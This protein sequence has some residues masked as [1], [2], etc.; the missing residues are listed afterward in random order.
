MPWVFRT[1]AYTSHGPQPGLC[2][3][4]ASLPQTAAPLLPYEHSPPPIDQCE[5]SRSQHHAC[6][7][8]ASQQGRAPRHYLLPECR[9]PCVRSSP[10]PFVQRRRWLG[11]R[12][13]GN[14]QGAQ[15]GSQRPDRRHRERVGQP[16]CCRCSCNVGPESHSGQHGGRHLKRDREDTDADTQGHTQGNATPMHHPQAWVL[17]QVAAHPGKP[18][19]LLQRLCSR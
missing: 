10:L 8:K 14:D 4:F 9:W 5:G 12:L 3:W 15:K 16:R 1:P 7:G 11:R 19:G 13:L 18:S 17:S 2:S 6:K